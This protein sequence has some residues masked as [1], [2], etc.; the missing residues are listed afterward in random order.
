[1]KNEI[2]KYLE[3]AYPQGLVVEMLDEEIIN[4]VDDVWEED[5]YD[6]EYDWYI[7]HMNGEAEDVIRDIIINSIFKEFNLD[8]QTYFNK[9]GEEVYETINE[10]YCDLDK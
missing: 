8:Y 3:T 5:G 4:W 1:M 7:D 10:I 9:T 6:S 2:I